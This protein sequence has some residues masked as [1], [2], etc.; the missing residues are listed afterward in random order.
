MD[1][2]IAFTSNQDRSS[3]C[4]NYS[5]HTFCCPASRFATCDIRITQSRLPPLGLL[6]SDTFDPAIACCFQTGF[7]RRSPTLHFSRLASTFD[8]LF[9]S[10]FIS[11]FSSNHILPHLLS[12]LCKTLK[13][14]HPTTTELHDLI[15]T[16]LFT[17]V[18]ECLYNVN[19][20]SKLLLKCLKKCH[21]C[22]HLTNK[23]SF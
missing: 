15:I 17:F 18:S 11:G 4:K 23:S 5:C 13:Y 21:T 20:V 19:S 1:G 10:T 22:N 2:N 7:L 3:C 8:S 12:Q 14:Q 16:E 9:P 6:F